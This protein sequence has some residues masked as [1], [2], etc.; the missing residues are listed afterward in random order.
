MVDGTLLGVMLDY[1]DNIV[2]QQAQIYLKCLSYTFFKI[3]SQVPLALIN[4]G[5]VVSK[6][7]SP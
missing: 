5:N 4:N 6:R 2:S 1:Y 7:L 3:E